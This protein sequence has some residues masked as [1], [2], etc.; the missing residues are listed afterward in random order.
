MSSAVLYRI[1]RWSWPAVALLALGAFLAGIPLE[2][3]KLNRGFLGLWWHPTSSGL[4][5]DSV[6]PGLSADRAGIR[7]GDVIILV[8]R[9]AVNR[10]DQSA[11]QTGEPGSHIN[12]LVRSPDGRLQQRYVIYDLPGRLAAGLPRAVYI[13][14]LI[15]LD[16]L[17]V[18]I[19]LGMSAL[20]VW[21]APSGWFPILAAYALVL[22][23]VRIPPELLLL[24]RTPG[25][26]WL[27]PLSQNLGFLLVPLSLALFPD[28]RWRPRW[29]WIY[30]LTA[31]V[32]GLAS[33]LTPFKAW[34]FQDNRPVLF[35]NLFIAIGLAVQAY[36]YWTS[37]SPVERRQIRWALFG[38]SAGALGYL[39][40]EL[41]F[42][43][44][45]PLQVFPGLHSDPVATYAYL[46]SQ[47]TFYLPLILVPPALAASILR[48][49]LWDVDLIIRRTLIYTLITA[50]LAATYF[51]LVVFLQWLFRQISGE[52][53][54]LALI[55]S[56]LAITV[57]FA[58]VRS[59]VQQAIDRRFFR[60]KYD[61]ART[62][63]VFAAA[64]RSDVD[65]NHLSGELLKVVDE[66][67]KP[68]ALS[69]WLLPHWRARR[70]GLPGG[71]DGED[72]GEDDRS[73]D[74]AERSK[75]LFQ[76]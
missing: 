76:P 2:A 47:R 61:A 37:T 13:G 10:E 73:P 50:S 35:E 21:R 48:F 69:L 54:N 58:P 42:T 64:A 63:E 72:A 28:G 60:K 49:R 19:F 65:L 30:P 20:I 68:A 3:Q 29:I 8:N 16:M 24:A 40:L 26:G 55:L 1:A 17:Y 57:L 7:P 9:Q 51:S 23:P 46:L 5:V 45:L 18:M 22:I 38:I 62:L 70:A 4:A 12:F 31:V 34:V 41:G 53:S 74:G 67:L 27:T 11:L 71:E 56:T 33:S 15:G 44:Q 43:Y 75:T 66:N 52:D 14:G 36:R 59:W 25:M 39:I 6:T 32:Y